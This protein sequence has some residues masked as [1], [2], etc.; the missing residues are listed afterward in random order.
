MAEEAKEESKKSNDTIGK[1]ARVD[2][3]G[4]HKMDDI[5][6]FRVSYPTGFKGVKHLGSKDGKI[7]KIHKL[8]GQRLAA[9]GIGEIVAT[10][11]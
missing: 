6:S 10:D 2:Q 4:E 3:A 1:T 5:V 11:N 7:I 9:K 8:V